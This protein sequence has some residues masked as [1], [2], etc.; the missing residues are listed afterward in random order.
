VNVPDQSAVEMYRMDL[1]PVEISF[2][3]PRPQ[4]N[5]NAVKGDCQ[6]APEF[7]TLPKD[8]YLLLKK[9][10][11]YYLVHPNLVDDP[12]ISILFNMN[13][14]TRPAI[15]ELRFVDKKC[16]SWT[17]LSVITSILVDVAV[18]MVFFIQRSVYCELV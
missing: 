9:C 7:R 1:N 4:A 14:K 2:F 3:D 6:C 13:L 18:T 8:G 5:M 15:S 10:F 17:H 16:A 11:L 12:R